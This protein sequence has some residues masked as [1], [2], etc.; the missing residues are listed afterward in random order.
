MY[1][2]ANLYSAKKRENESDALTLGYTCT[3]TIDTHTTPHTHT[4]T[5]THLAALC[6]GLPG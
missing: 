6:P 2:H 3:Q 1:I 5:H 4:H